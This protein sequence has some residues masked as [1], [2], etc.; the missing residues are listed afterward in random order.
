MIPVF[1]RPEQSCDAAVGYS[2]SAG[3]PAQVVADWQKH[4]AG[5]IR[6]DTFNPASRGILSE[7][8]DPLYVDNVLDG[9][10]KNGFGNTDPDVAKSLLYTTGSMLAAAKHVLT[11]SR[12]NGRPPVA[13]SPTSGF[14][15]AGYNFGGGY[16]TF[17]GLMVTAMRLKTLGLVNKVLILDFDQHNG[18][19]TQ[20][21]IDT[22]GIDWIKHVTAGKSYDTADEVLSIARNLKPYAAGGKYEV[23]L[24]LYQAG[25]DQHRDDPLGGLLTT[26]QMLQ[27]D[28]S[29]F[30]TCNQ[31]SIPL[32]FNL[33][34]GYKKDE[35]GTIA[36]VLALH[37]QTMAACIDQY[38]GG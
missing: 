21:I 24:I 22:L 16:C 13:C 1:Y 34:G 19:G 14:H 11:F 4:F 27:R 29:I 26:E 8:H 17:N 3:K 23:D 12:L 33:A 10:V 7:A 28:T 6:I 37:R 25:V 30:K 31:Y 9:H 36:P 2:P 18:N 20:N 5:D 38:Y 15:H 35:R 32:V